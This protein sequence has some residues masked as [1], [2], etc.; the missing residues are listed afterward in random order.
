MNASPL[1]SGLVLPPG[2]YLLE[3][4]LGGGRTTSPDELRRALETCGFDSVVAD[5]PGL[6]QV[7]PVVGAAMMSRPP[8]GTSP[9]GPSPPA[10]A[11]RASALAATFRSVTPTET[12]KIDTSTSS[13]TVMTRLPPAGAAR[14]RAEQAAH[15][16]VTPGQTAEIPT[17]PASTMKPRGLFGDG[18]GGGDGGG[19]GG[20][21]PDATDGGGGGPGGAG[22]GPDFAVDPTDDRYAIDKNTGQRYYLDGDTGTVYGV[23]PK[24]GELLPVDQ[25]SLAPTGGRKLPPPPPKGAASRATGTGGTDDL[26]SVFERG[27]VEH[28]LGEDP[29]FSMHV[30]A[31]MRGL[32][33]PEVG[34][35][36]V[37]ARTPGRVVLRSAPDLS[38]AARRLAVDPY[39]PVPL[40][41]RP[42]ILSPGRTYDMIV[43]GRDRRARS[44]GDVF[45][46]AEAIGFEPHAIALLQRDLHLPKRYATSYSRWLLVGTWR[47]PA[48]ITTAEEP[49]LFADVQEGAP[50]S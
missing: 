16:S 31:T 18:G 49:L 37:V 35:Y 27:D 22:G 19:D 20:A 39:E 23:D 7:P 40:Q 25:D 30:G 6:V 9:G 1:P 44:R 26:A 48:T 4:Q 10:P 41:T 32:S 11:G 28:P 47:G 45:T 14:F 34:T 24:T 38:W 17:G 13:S 42:F 21:G 8:A 15:L 46:L 33:R 36:R 2:V 29:A 5:E 3:L 12:A 50:P 43:L